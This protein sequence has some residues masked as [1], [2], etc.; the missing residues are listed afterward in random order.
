[1]KDKRN[2]GQQYVRLGDTIYAVEKNEEIANCVVISE[3]LVE[4]I[5]NSVSE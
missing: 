5:R 4:A 3:K 1:M 2:V